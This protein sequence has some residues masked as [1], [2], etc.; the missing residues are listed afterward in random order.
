M[1]MRLSGMIRTCALLA[2]ICM[3]GIAQAQFITARA[4]HASQFLSDNL[5]DA[6]LSHA[7]GGEVIYS[8][9]VDF[10]K[11]PIDYNLGADYRMVDGRH[12]VYAVTGLSWITR[13]PSGFMFAPNAE[14]VTYTTSNWLH[15]ADVNMYNGVLITDTTTTYSMGWSLGYNIG[16]VFGKQF[17]VHTG[18]GARYNLTPAFKAD[19]EMADNSLDI[20]FKAGVLWKFKRKFY[21]A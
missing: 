3:T 16:Y 8:K 2:I 11:L 17:F 5:Y 14:S 19:E 12:E 7:I 9:P 13:T 1:H 15:Y 21:K 4:T 20:L 6:D 18:F 10:I